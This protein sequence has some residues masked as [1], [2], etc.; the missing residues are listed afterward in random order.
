MRNIVFAAA[1]AAMGSVAS[2]PSV[3]AQVAN[4]DQTLAIA[5]ILDN[6]SFDRAQ[7]MIA[8]QM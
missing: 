5:A 4:D 3:L 8:N 1:V 7:L 6:N 2:A